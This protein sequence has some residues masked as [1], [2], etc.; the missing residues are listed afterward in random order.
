MTTLTHSEQINELAIALAKA[1]GKIEGAKKGVENTFFKSK[2]ADL[3]AVWD[4]VRGPL[5]ENGIAV[6]QSPF[7]DGAHV[8]VDTMLVHTTGQWMRGVVVATAKD[9]GP[10]AV[11]SCI[12][13]LRRYALQSFVGVAAEDDDG[14]AAEAKDKP[15]AARVEMPAPSRFVTWLAEL[16]EAADKGTETLKG[17]WLT[18]PPECR[19]HLT[20]TQP[21]NWEDL[22]AHAASI[23]PEQSV[24]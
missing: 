12:T 17:F 22:K 23:K 2:Y 10:Q 18:S 24:A 20:D 19:K 5:T 11:G 16:T 15:Q 6:I 21:Q 3:A 8:G 7:T 4:A 14:N 9:E 1:Q 13:Y